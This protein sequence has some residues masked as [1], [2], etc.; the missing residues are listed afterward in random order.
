MNST[1]LEEPTQLSHT[2]GESTLDLAKIQEQINAKLVLLVVRRS[3]P[4]FGYK[5]KGNGS[6][7]E[8]TVE[9]TINGNKID[10]E[11]LSQQAKLLD[12]STQKLINTAISNVTAFV[13]THTLPWYIS[14]I[15]VLPAQNRDTFFDQLPT[16]LES[17]EEHKR[18]FLDRYAESRPEM[19]RWWQ[20][21]GASYKQF[22]KRLP[23]VE[24]L[25]KRIKVHVRTF[26]MQ[27]DAAEDAAEAVEELISSV[28]S[29][30]AKSMEELAGTLSNS[31]KLTDKT[32]NNLKAAIKIAR[33]FS[34]ICDPKLN[35]HVEEL[36]TKIDQTVSAVTSV[37]RGDSMT[38]IVRRSTSTLQAA[39]DQTMAACR[40]PKGL[41]DSM[42]KFGAA[43]RRLAI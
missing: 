28:R 31:S 37:D 17:F 9:T 11:K 3:C 36:E 25:E 22:A 14:P 18:V 38:S 34:D 6:A 43:P 23:P 40:D 4:T 20:Q 15:R 30:L 29:G 39:L 1:M 2:S 7:A 33:G 35:R 13:E 12:K 8:P 21:Q 26:G 42:K 16:I 19:L 27:F 32:F 10:D 24:D 5:L 41:R